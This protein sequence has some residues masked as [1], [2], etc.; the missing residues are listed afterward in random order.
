MTMQNQSSEGWEKASFHCRSRTAQV[1]PGPPCVST[2]VVKSQSRRVS[3]G[4]I[5]KPKV[6]G[7]HARVLQ[8]DHTCVMNRARFVPVR[9]LL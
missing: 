9:K 3:G 1:G 6:A 5:A 4:G 7:K 8:S 2:N